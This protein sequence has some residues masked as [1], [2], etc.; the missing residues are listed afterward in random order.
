MSKRFV[1]CLRN[2]LQDD[3]DVGSASYTV[4]TEPCT[5][6]VEVGSF[7]FTDAGHLLLGMFMSHSPWQL[8]IHVQNI[9]N[10]VTAVALYM[11][12]PS[13]LSLSLLLLLSSPH[14]WNQLPK[15]LRIPHP[16]Y[17]SPSRRPSFEDAGLT[18][19]TLLSPSITFSLFHSELE[20]YLF[21]KSYTPH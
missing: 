20:T 7:F 9:V 17:S 3:L 12:L 2:L 11:F 16:N 13:L 8:N 5:S 1:G 4:G 6:N 19:Y 10:S 21:R 15:S 18:C 14:L